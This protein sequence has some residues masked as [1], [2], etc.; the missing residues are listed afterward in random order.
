MNYTSK[1]MRTAGLTFSICTTV[2]LFPVSFMMSIPSI[3]L[4]VLLLGE[5]SAS[6]LLYMLLLCMFSGIFM[7][8]ESIIR[9]YV[10]R[11]TL[12]GLP[13]FFALELL[14]VSPIIIRRIINK[15]NSKRQP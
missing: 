7:M 10:Y 2:V 11:S 9:V 6:R 3:V 13:E 14:L 4:I 12:N 5:K 8:P 1:L 15:L